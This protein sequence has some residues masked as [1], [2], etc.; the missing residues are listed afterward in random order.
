[1][2]G[3]LRKLVLAISLVG[4][5]GLGYVSLRAQSVHSPEDDAAIRAAL[6]AQVAAWNRSDIPAFME[7]YENSPDTTFIGKTVAKGFAP[8]L[9]RY[10]KSYST[11]AQMGTL[12]F[13]DL[14][15]RLLPSS[16]G[17]TEY[18]VVTGKFHLDRGAKGAATSDDGIFSLV[19][20][21]SGGHWKIMLDH[22]SS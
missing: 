20:H 6:N 11:R 7:T 21:K 3:Y 19:W 8:I 16:S 2:R 10:K 12:T 9:E 13:K 15:V 4:V 22:T 17:T 5:L 18:A 14:E 1:M